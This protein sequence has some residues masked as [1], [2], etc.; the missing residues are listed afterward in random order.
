MTRRKLKQLQEGTEKQYREQMQS[1]NVIHYFPLHLPILSANEIF[2]MDDQT[3]SGR[4]YPLS[5]PTCTADTFIIRL[6][7]I[8]LSVF[9]TTFLYVCEE[10][11][12]VQRRVQTILSSRFSKTRLT[13]KVLKFGQFDD[14]GHIWLCYHW[15]AENSYLSAS[16]GNSDIT[17]GFSESV[18]AE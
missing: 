17:S 5:L 10:P 8:L 3:I 14:S 11:T 18:N 1:C 15:E 13:T 4:F 6:V 2:T 9:L 12:A 7:T 16:G